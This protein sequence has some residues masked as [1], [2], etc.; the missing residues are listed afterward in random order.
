MTV[1]QNSCVPNARPPCHGEDY[2][3]LVLFFEQQPDIL[4]NEFLVWLSAVRLGTVDVAR[5]RKWRKLN[6][7]CCERLSG[8][9]ATTKIYFMYVVN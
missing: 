7:F 1:T 4:D 2:S 5:L 9:F 8:C 3:L 6:R